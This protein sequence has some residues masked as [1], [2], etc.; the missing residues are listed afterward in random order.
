MRASVE[1]LQTAYDTY[2]EKHNIHNNRERRN[3]SARQAF[4][5]AARVYFTTLEIARVTK[6]NHAT[7]IH[8][9][10]SHET[11][12]K[13]DTHYGRFF[14]EC[15]SIMMGLKQTETLDEEWDLLVENAELRQQVADLR[16]ELRDTRRELRK[17]KTKKKYELCD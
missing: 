16:L 8:A 13:F 10:R 7:V 15:G 3:V 4:M 11:N 14:I 5:T 1:E 17:K 6:K 2:I 9:T 12:I